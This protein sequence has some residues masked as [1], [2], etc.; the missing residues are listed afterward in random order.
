MNAFAS[1]TRR[2]RFFS[3]LCL[4]GTFTAKNKTPI[5]CSVG[6]LAEKDWDFLPGAGAVIRREN[7]LTENEPFV[8]HEVIALNAPRQT[9]SDNEYSLFNRGVLRHL[10]RF[11]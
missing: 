6:R 8:L 11:L 4:L 2:K 5:N 3:S 7:F 1:E 9:R 10:F